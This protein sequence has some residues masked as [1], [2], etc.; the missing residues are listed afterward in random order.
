MHMMPQILQSK[1]VFYSQ[2]RGELQSSN[3][4]FRHMA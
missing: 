1:S 3:D 4:F 2:N